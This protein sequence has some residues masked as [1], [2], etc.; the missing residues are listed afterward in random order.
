[1]L[2]DLGTPTVPTLENGR[3]VDGDLLNLPPG[4]NGIPPR[5]PALQ[6]QPMQ[7]MQPQQP[8]SLQPVQP[9]MPE[10]LPPQPTMPRQNM[11]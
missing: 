9:A 2:P 11:Q 5:N 8:Q 10:T 4:A 1:V 6:M 3:M 7:P